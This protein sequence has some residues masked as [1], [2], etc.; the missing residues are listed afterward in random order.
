MSN[1]YAKDWRKLR[2]AVFDTETTGLNPKEHRLVEM[3]IVVFENGLPV[4]KFCRLINPTRKIDAGA[5]KVHGISA[6]DVANKKTFLQLSKKIR[7][8]LKSVDIWCAFNEHFDRGFLIEE[9]RR[10]KL[11][12]EVKPIL[13][14][15]IIARYIWQN[16]PNNLDNVAQRLRIAPQK[17]TLDALGINAK[18]HRADYDSLVTGLALYAF[19]RYLPTELD[20]TL[21]VQHWMYKQNIARTS[22]GGKSKF[23]RPLEPTLPPR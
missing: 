14:P 4:E 23:E 19:G 5:Q 22:S 9:F 8:Y 3:G 7:K 16:M 20:A 17:S 2:L 1:I 11:N 12:F 6:E 21:F 18:R 13:D 10:A 15:L